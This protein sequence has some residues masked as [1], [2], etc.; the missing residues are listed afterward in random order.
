MHK[1][2]SV[3]V[4]RSRLRRSFV[5]AS[6]PRGQPRT[7]CRLAACAVASGGSA[8]VG[9]VSGRPSRCVV[10]CG[11]CDLSADCSTRF[12]EFFD[13][14]SAKT[15][16]FPLP[17]NCKAS[18]DFCDLATARYGTEIYISTFRIHI[19]YP[20]AESHTMISGHQNSYFSHDAKMNLRNS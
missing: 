13:Q 10:S 6:A 7:L 19:G 20:P 14:I 12:R 11:A 16:R 3:Y 2:S 18:A 4:T 17:E 5:A 8:G 1:S 15:F 9:S